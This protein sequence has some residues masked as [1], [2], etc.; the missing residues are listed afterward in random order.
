M[1]PAT[2]LVMGATGAIGSAL[3]DMLVPDH[4][5]GHL[6]LVVATRRPDAA[7]WLRECGV[8]VRRLDLDEAETAGLEAVRPA[9]AGVQAGRTTGVLRQHGR[10]R[11]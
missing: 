2:V 9:F 11:R 5:E 7:A 10:G 4:Q 1:A 8:E 3:V 6:R